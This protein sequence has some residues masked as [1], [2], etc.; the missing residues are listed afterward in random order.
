VV[1]RALVIPGNRRGV[2]GVVAPVTAALLA[3]AV[4]LAVQPVPAI[5]GVGTYL[6]DVADTLPALL[7]GDPVA[8]VVQPVALLVLGIHRPRAHSAPK[9]IHA[10]L[11][12]VV[13]FTHL[14]ERPAVADLSVR[15]LRFDIPTGIATVLYS[16]VFSVFSIHRL[17]PAVR[18]DRPA[19]PGE[20]IAAVPLRAIRVALAPGAAIRQGFA[21]TADAVHPQGTV[22]IRGA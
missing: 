11:D 9:P 19:L 7:V 10:L 13:T 15:A 22:L 2:E 21:Q 6:A 16:P 8:V 20:H 12:P 5:I 18:I 17:P 3:L 4:V 1:D 14:G